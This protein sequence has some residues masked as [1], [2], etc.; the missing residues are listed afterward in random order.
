MRVYGE[1]NGMYQLLLVSVTIRNILGPHILPL[2]LYYSKRF[3]SASSQGK[4]EQQARTPLFQESCK[5]V[6]PM[7]NPIP[8]ANAP[9]KMVLANIPTGELALGAPIR[10]EG[11]VF[12]HC[13]A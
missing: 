13:C 3:K 9:A 4:S 11:R 6:T 1:E 10:R 12:I 2:F 5:E 8:K 7:S